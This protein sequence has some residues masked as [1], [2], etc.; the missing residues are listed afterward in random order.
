M[1]SCNE[2]KTFKI[3]EKFYLDGNT[4]EKPDSEKEIEM[5]VYA[6]NMFMK[7]LSREKKINPLESLNLKRNQES[8]DGVGESEGGKSGEFFFSSFDNKLMIKT[9]KKRDFDIFYKHFQDYF[10]YLLDKNPKSYITRVYL[11]KIYSKIKKNIL[12][13]KKCCDFV[14][15]L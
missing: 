10:E 4:Q 1:H 7:V 6:G 12:K 11:Q 5:E 2:R 14:L 13:M 3:Q 9:V 8:I 15:F